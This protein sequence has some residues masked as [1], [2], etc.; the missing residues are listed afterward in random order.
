VDETQ[1]AAQH[2]FGNTTFV[3]EELREMQG[4]ASVE[5]LCQDL[6]YALRLWGRAPGFAAI[7]VLTLALG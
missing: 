4:W 2:A 5:P 6:R 1:Y 7:V 3:K